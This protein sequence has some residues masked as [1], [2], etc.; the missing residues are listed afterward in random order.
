MGIHCIYIWYVYTD[1]PAFYYRN[2][3]QYD[4]IVLSA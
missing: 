3:P 4:I 1:K 2:S